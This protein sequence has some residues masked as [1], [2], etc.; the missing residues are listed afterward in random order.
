MHFKKRFLAI[1][2]CV[3]CGLLPVMTQT[4]S[5]ASTSEPADKIVG[6]T[7]AAWKK[8]GLFFGQAAFNIH[9]IDGKKEYR[10]TFLDW[11]FTTEAYYYGGANQTDPQPIIA[12]GL[13][14]SVDLRK[15]TD[16]YVMVLYTL[17]STSSGTRKVKI[18]SHANMQLG[19]S[20]YSTICAETEGGKT[21][22]VSGTPKNAYALKLVATTC[23]TV[24]Y[25]VSRDQYEKWCVDMPNRG[26]DNKY[27]SGA[28][29]YSW[30]AIIAPGETWQRYVLI[31]TGSQYE[32]NKEAPTIATPDENVPDPSIVLN[33]T[34]AYVN[35][36]E[37]SDVDFWKKYIGY[38]V[39][40]VTTSGAPTKNSVPGIYT[41][42]YK[43]RK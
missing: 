5:A 2:L 39:G 9:G 31:G 25:G 36:G 28:L 43:A 10:T 8:S 42:T 11:G 35:E 12:T 20:Y 26:P 29:T 7:I 1:V 22:V 27:R 30:E 3:L 37:I 16:N 24:W 33:S 21:L 34:E 17:T 18:G 40:D 32:M 41:V 14:L 23:D 6:T 4:A 15:Y 38:S 19:S 13:R